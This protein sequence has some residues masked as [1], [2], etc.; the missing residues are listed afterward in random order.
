ME[1]RKNCSK[2]VLLNHQT[3]WL[4]NKLNF[5]VWLDSDAKLRFSKL[6]FNSPIAKLKI[7]SQTKELD[8]KFLADG[9]GLG[10]V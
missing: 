3:D 7:L 9:F 6:I 5:L 4:Y 1:F 8:W 2:E 10:L